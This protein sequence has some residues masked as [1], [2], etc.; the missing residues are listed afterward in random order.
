MAGR[1]KEQENWIGLPMANSQYARRGATPAGFIAGLW[2]GFIAPISAFAAMGNPVVRTH[3]SQ[4]SGKWY[5][6]GYRIG[7]GDPFA[8]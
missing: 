5:R 4:N 7:A 8:L 2:H 3:E 6:V 1:R